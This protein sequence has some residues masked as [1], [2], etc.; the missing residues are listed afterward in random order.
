MPFKG[1]NSDRLF[2]AQNINPTLVEYDA[3][4]NVPKF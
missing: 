4:F 1:E 3:I 2:S